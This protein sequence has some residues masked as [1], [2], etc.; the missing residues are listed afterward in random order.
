MKVYKVYIDPGHGGSDPGALGPT[1]LKEKDINLGIAFKVGQILQRHGISTLLTRQDDRRVELIDRVKMANNDR[2]DYFISIHANSASN[3]AAMG[4]ETFAF[5]N[6][7]IGTKLADA[8]Q[9]S[10]VN[11]IGLANRGVKHGDFFVLKNTKMPAILVEVAFINNPK[12]EKLLKD[13]NFSDKAATGI[14]KGI[15]MFLGM[16]YKEENY[17]DKNIS[18]W[19][20]DAMEWATDKEINLTDGSMPK[21]PIS[22]ERLIT[23]LHRYHNL[24]G[25]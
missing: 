14:S 20:K 24:F 1:G 12:E 5:P 8:V 3:P 23:I 13:Q 6:S 16:E 2:A 15:L 11:E 18:P 9:K 17:I 25:K 7:D 19:A 4:T 10:L 21:E 22:L